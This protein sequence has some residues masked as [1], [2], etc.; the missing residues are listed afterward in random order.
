VGGT[1]P[2]LLEALAAGNPVLAHD[3]PFNRWV[4]G[5]ASLYFADAAD[6]DVALTGL[7]QD[8]SRLAAMQACSL[9]RFEAEFR[10]ASVLPAYEALLAGA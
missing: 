3:N 10:W 4:A 7:L 9:A 8:R 6:F 1:N 5:D 2:S